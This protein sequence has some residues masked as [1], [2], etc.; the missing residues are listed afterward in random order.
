[1]HKLYR[2]IFGVVFV[3]S[4]SEI[5]FA[6]SNRSELNDAPKIE[7]SISKT[8][9]APDENFSLSWE[10]VSPHLTTDNNCSFSV[11]NSNKE[12]LSSEIVGQKERRDGF[13]ISRFDV[14]RMGRNPSFMI[15]C[16]NINGSSEKEISVTVSEKK[17]ETIL[18]TVK[19]SFSKVSNIVSGK[20]GVL[21]SIL[22]GATP[23]FAYSKNCVDVK[24]NLHRGNETAHV[25]T[26]QNFLID[27]GFLSEKATGF[28]GDLTIEAVKKYQRSIGLQETGMVYTKTRQAI[29][30]ETCE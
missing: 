8:E 16:Q 9:V 28:F 30:S 27:K 2:V 1:M 17:S 20:S 29:M 14:A 3:F 4:F 25:S 23:T 12:V 18:S 13:I 5:S 21:L 24:K 11:K 6:E 7:F 22:S 26:L 19:N 10:V 15:L